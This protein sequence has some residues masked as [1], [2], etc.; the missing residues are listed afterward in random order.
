MSALIVLFLLPLLW[1]GAVAAIRHLVRR[2]NAS[3]DDAGEKTMLAIVLAPVLLGAAL[4]AFWRLTPLHWTL[5]AIPAVDLPTGAAADTPASPFAGPAT[6]TPFNF[7]AWVLPTLWLLY[8][9]GLL[10]K[11]TTLLIAFARLR[12]IAALATPTQMVGVTVHLT[13]APV[14]PMALGRTTIILPTLLATSLDASDLRLL[15]DHERTHLNRRD[16]I[17]FALLSWIDAIFWFNPFVLTQTQHCRTAAEIACDS[18]VVRSGSADAYAQLLVGTLRSLNEA[19]ENSH[20]YAPAV[21]APERIA[22]YRQRLQ[23]I[24]R[25]GEARPPR[26]L[27]YAALIVAGLPFGLAQVA[28]S[29]ERPFPEQST[30]EVVQALA[31][32]TVIHI[33]HSDRCYGPNGREDCV[34]V[35]ID[36]GG[37]ITGRYTIVGGH[38]PKVGDKVTGGQLLAAKGGPG[39]ASIQ[40]KLRKDGKGIDCEPS[41]C[42]LTSNA[43]DGTKDAAI[44]WDHAD[45]ILTNWRVHADVMI[46]DNTT[47]VVGARGHVKIETG[48]NRAMLQQHAA[49][50]KRSGD[51]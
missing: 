18:A 31:D 47:G 28:Y 34:G 27:L 48:D 32:G 13:Q 23:A 16:P 33:G 41:S 15:L 5:P 11:T 50:L 30:D 21:F 44:L 46:V 12:R 6:S 43:V 40:L 14:S 49:A 51:L 45:L 10:W 36:H 8:G 39:N 20:R 1:S 2:S 7:V 3:L 42:S 26:R 35:E 29:Q 25:P 4:F 24:L 38:T 22:G 9:A 37:G 19:V 17:Y